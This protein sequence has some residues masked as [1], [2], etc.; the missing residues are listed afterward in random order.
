MRAT[1]TTKSETTTKP[2]TNLPKSH[3]NL[4]TSSQTPIEIALKIDENG[5]TSLR[6]LYEFLELS[7][8]QFTRW[9]KRN[10]LNNPF[11]TENIDYL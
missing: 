7:S 4:D 1:K 10:V 2:I 8:S 6:N 11:A 5:M 3:S 9:C